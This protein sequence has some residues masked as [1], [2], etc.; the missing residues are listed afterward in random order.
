MQDEKTVSERADQSNELRDFVMAQVRENPT[1]AVWRDLLK[2]YIE[3]DIANKNRKAVQEDVKRYV[4][5]ME[6]ILL[7]FFKEHLAPILA[8]IIEQGAVSPFVVFEA[9]VKSTPLKETQ[10]PKKANDVDSTTNK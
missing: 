1:D 8:K 3:A 7:P 5:L 2:S 9:F 10:H 4:E 6:P